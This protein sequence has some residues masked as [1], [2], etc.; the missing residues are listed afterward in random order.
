MLLVG[1]T[2]NLELI[3][4]ETCTVD[5]VVEYA[6]YVSGASPSFSVGSVQGKI[7]SAT[8]TNVVPAPSAG[9]NRKIK[10]LSI[11]NTN[12]TTSVRVIIVKDVSA[13]QYNIT[14]N[15]NLGPGE[16]LIFDGTDQF[17]LHDSSG[18]REQLNI[19]S[20]TGVST[21]I[22]FRKIGLASEAASVT[23]CYSNTA[24]GFPGLWTP[25][26][27]GLSGYAPSG[28]QTDP[29]SSGS[30]L[31]LPSTSSGGTL[32]LTSFEASATVVNDV[33]LFDLLWYNSGTVVTTTTAQTINSVNFAPR[34]INGTISGSDVQV[35]ILVHVATTNAGAVTNTTMTYT[36]SLGLTGRTATMTSFPATAVAGTI[37][38]F[39]LQAGDT[40]VRK[41]DSITLGTSYGAGTIHLIAFRYITSVGCNVVNT[42]FQ[43][44]IKEPGIK[45][46]PGT[47]LLIATRSPTATTA[48]T[49]AGS[50][51]VTE[52]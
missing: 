51:I 33:S 5:Y 48:T 4:S 38:P 14:P 20:T 37:V 29:F 43:A 11:S 49:V 10:A 18:R 50:I 28:S 9:V 32:Y 52:R 47:N 19:N 6:D 15:C 40:G 17:F 44:N 36:S 8:T 39:N 30:C 7:T 2:E 3:T 22:N 21:C 46:W 41:I 25:G 13:T 16:T 24:A 1:N 35:G 27:V 26:T 31:P 23:N 45:L 42:S 34:D 12:S